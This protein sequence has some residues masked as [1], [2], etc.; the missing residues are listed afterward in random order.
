MRHRQAVTKKKALAYRSADRAGEI[1]MLDDLVALTCWHREYAG[2]AS[3]GALTVK[4]VMPRRGRAP[5]Y[6]PRVTTVLVKCRAMLRAPAGKRVAPTLAV[7]VPLLRRDGELDVT[8]AESALLLKIAPATID[9]RLAEDR[10][11]LIGRGRGIHR[12]CARY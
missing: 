6:G 5:T 4:V 9:R 11:K 2:A 7:L 1:R 10:A 8:N 3:R 12:E